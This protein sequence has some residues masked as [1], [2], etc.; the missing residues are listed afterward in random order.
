[1]VGASIAVVQI[2]T[3]RTWK[4]TAIAPRAHSAFGRVIG[5]ERVP[6][7]DSDLLHERSQ[8]VRTTW[9]TISATSTAQTP[10]AD[11]DSTFTGR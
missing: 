11:A 2:A 3:S 9:V 5:L 10:R 7:N 6:F 1:M 4:R 8:I